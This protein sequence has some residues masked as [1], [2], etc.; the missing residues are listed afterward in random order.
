MRI[1]YF[2]ARSYI[3]ELNSICSLCCSGFTFSCG[4]NE[5][6][7]NRMVIVRCYRHLFNSLSFIN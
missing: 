4:A 7:E 3:K 2:Q 5:E 6:L 1:N